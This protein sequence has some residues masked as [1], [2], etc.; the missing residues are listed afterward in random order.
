MRE[1]RGRETRC[2][3][4][5][6]TNMHTNTHA[7]AHTH[8]MHTRTEG[9]DQRWRGAI[10]RRR[11]GAIAGGGERSEVEGSDRRRRGAIAGGGERSQRVTFDLDPASALVSGSGRRPS[12]AARAFSLF[13]WEA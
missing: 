13:T 11:R 5:T 10:D 9:S 6:H 7:R 4:H 3:A 8:R 1:L 12:Q 2:S